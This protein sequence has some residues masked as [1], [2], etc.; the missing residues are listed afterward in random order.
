MR[1]AARVF[2]LVSSLLVILYGILPGLFH[3]QGNFVAAYVVGK[4]FLGG[5]DPTSFYRFPDFQKLVNASG[6][7][8][9][10]LSFSAW[11][12]A[13]IPLDSLISIPPPL[14]SKFILTALNI[15]ALV[16]LVHAS[17]KVSRVSVRMSYSIF[18]ASSFAL[19]SNFGPSQPYIVLALLLVLA[20]Y[21]ASFDANGTAGV[22]LGII[23]PFKVFAAIPA[24]LFLISKK[25]RAFFFFVATS[26]VL[27]AVTYLIVGEPVIK[28]YLQRVFPFYLDGR[29][30]NPFS[31]SH[32]TAWSFFRNLF[33][34]NATLNARPLLSSMDAYILAVS[35]FKAIV[36]VPPCYFFYKGIE[37]KD[38]RESLIAASFPI[39][40]LSPTGTTAQMILLAPAI[41]S[42]VQIALETERVKMARFF[43]IVYAMLCIPIYAA[44]DTYLGV[45]TPF[46]LFERFLLLI[47]LYVTYFVFQLH[48]VPKHL[49]VARAAATA[50]VVVAVSV[51]LYFGDHTP[52]YHFPPSVKSA[53]TGTQLKGPAFSPGLTEG[54]MTYI[55][56]DSSSR[57][58][59]PHD[60]TV[61]AGRPFNCYKYVSDKYGESYAIQMVERGRNN[62]YFRTEN[63]EASYAG[64][65]VSVSTDGNWGLFLRNGSLYLLEMERK[66]IM[67]SDSLDLMPFKILEASFNYGKNNEITFVIDSLNGSQAVAA[68][69]FLDR[70]LTTFH[71]PF[72]FSLL[73]SNSNDFYVTREYG[74]STSIWM[75]NGEGLPKKLLSVHGNISDVT[76]IGGRLYF[77]SDF[78]RGLN[79]PTIYEY[80]PAGSFSLRN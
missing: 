72:H 20:F 25:W 76:V 28:Y 45:T 30:M 18:L 31:T 58:L 55:S 71:A 79:L 35:I 73:S 19:A 32:Q 21:A 46:L 15:V 41:I 65:S 51:T 40:F 50:G 39:V 34:Y 16:L 67:L 47:V 54:R 78:G 1:L 77:S 6:L 70:K 4:G 75:F 12:P 68:Y 29:I 80:L 74:D 8:H 53:I 3:S 57:S 66:R 37:R 24:V 56:L 60:V 36:I 44:L 59:V 69:N 52:G 26:L 9:A 23:F 43:V 13:F 63:A 7:S 62:C 5:I 48:L 61:Q 38:L 14:V 17:A 11:T 2:V 42:M 10:L 27:M 22:A 49:W 64:N 33:V